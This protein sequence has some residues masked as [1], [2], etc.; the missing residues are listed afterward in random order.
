MLIKLFNEY[1]K[2]LSNDNKFIKLTDHLKP[3]ILSIFS[4]IDCSY[5]LKEDFIQECHIKLFNM[6]KNKEF[7]EINSYGLDKYLERS[8]KTVK[9]EFI[10]KYHLNKKLISLD[11]LNECGKAL[12]ETIS[13]PSEEENEY[14]RKN[15]RIIK[16]NLS[17]EEFKLF[18]L[19]LNIDGNKN[20]SLTE[21]AKLLGVTPQA[22]HKR[23]KKIKEKIKDLFL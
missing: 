21:V 20:R 1:K 13:D 4:T 16:T 10:K 7:I 6:A 8:F 17:E 15:I 11:G 14:I 9:Q 5:D 19:I 12:I 2:D 22:I 3:K 23:F 18:E